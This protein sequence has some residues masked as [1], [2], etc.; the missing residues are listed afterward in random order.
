MA[1]N[2]ETLK[3]TLVPYGLNAGPAILLP[4]PRMVRI[5]LSG[6]LDR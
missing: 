4:C 5:L 3:A 6:R 2:F 1:L